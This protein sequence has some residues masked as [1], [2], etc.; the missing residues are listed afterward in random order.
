MRLPL[1]ALCL[2][3]VIASMLTP[4]RSVAAEIDARPPDRLTLSGNGSRLTDVGVDEDGYGGSLNYRDPIFQKCKAS[5]QPLH[6][7]LDANAT[8]GKRIDYVMAKLGNGQ[9]LHSMQDSGVVCQPLER[10]ARV[11]GF[12][13]LKD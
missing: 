2:S 12:L 8:T 13:R 5:T 7:C 6:A 4:A 9:V 3:S 1:A 10:I 11:E